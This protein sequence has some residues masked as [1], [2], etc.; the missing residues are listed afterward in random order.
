MQYELICCCCHLCTEQ[1]YGCCC[2]LRCGILISKQTAL[3]IL[4]IVECCLVFRLLVTVNVAPSSPILVTQMMEA[5][6][7]SE[8]SVRTIATRHY[9]PED[10]I[11]RGHHRENFKSYILQIVCDC[12][13]I[14]SLMNRQLTPNCFTG[15]TYLHS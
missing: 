12:E 10:G 9:I 15:A 13:D 5:I 4:Q 14:F 1:L 6:R 8:C 11:L 3:Y 2:H 7:S